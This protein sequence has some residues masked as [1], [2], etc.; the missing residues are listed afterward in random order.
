M[1]AICGGFQMMGFSIH[2]PDRVEAAISCTDGLGLLP[3]CTHFTAEKVTRKREL[4]FLKAPDW[5]PGMTGTPLGGYEIHMG[6][7]TLLAEMEPHSAAM[8]DPHDGTQEGCLHSARNF[9]GTLIHGL[10]D[11]THL[12]LATINALRRAK[13]LSPMPVTQARSQKK[14]FDELAESWDQHVDMPAI[15]KILQLPPRKTHA[16]SYQ[17]S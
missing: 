1:L 13:G 7:V 3:I 15:L 12:R 10:F 8:Q 2:D 6:Q 16:V 9:L 17:L 11:N 5:M 4:H 14:A